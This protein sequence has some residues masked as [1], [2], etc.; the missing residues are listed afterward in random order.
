MAIVGVGRRFLLFRFFLRGVRQWSTFRAMIEF[1]SFHAGRRTEPQ[2]SGACLKLPISM[3]TISEACVFWYVVV[4]IIK[5]AHAKNTGFGEC[6]DGAT[7]GRIAI[8]G[9]GMR[10]CFAG[11]F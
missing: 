9:I 8:V 3:L 1:D 7:A 10:S 2:S 5:S 11:C 4:D 6:F